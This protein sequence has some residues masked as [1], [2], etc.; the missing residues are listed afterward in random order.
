MIPESNNMLVT[1]TYMK[2]VKFKIAP[3]LYAHLCNEVE[4][5]WCIKDTLGNVYNFIE[6]Q[7]EFEPPNR[8]EKFINETR[9]FL[10]DITESICEDAICI[11]ESTYN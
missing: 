4:D 11:F 3:K 8:T 6:H 7:F 2:P 5:L 1:M 10:D 9:C